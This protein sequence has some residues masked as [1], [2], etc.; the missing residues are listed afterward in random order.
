VPAVGGAPADVTK[1]TP[2]Q[3]AHFWPCFLPDGRQFL[4]YARGAAAGLYLGSLDSPDSKRIANSDTGAQFVAP[5]WLLF[6]HRGTLVAQRLDLARGEL[7][8][9]PVS[10]ADQV[11]VVAGVV[12][13]GAFS[14]SP[15]GS[16]TYRAGRTLESQLT[17]FTRSGKVAGTIGKPDADELLRPMLSPDGRRVVAQR[18]VRGNTDLWLFDAGRE[19][20]LT[21]DP[22][23]ELG[24]VWS[25]DGSRIAFSRDLKG[26]LRLYQKSIT[27][28]GAEEL[29]LAPSGNPL[30]PQAWSP[31]GRLLLYAERYPLT[32]SDLW[33]LPLDGK[34][35]FVFVNSKFEDRM[36]QFSPDGRWVAYMSDE[37]GRPEIYLRSF[38]ASGGQFSVSTTGGIMPRWR[39][40]GKELYYIAPDGTLM[41]V[42][43][44]TTGRAPEM[45]A[46]VALF[47]P[48]ILYGGRLIPGIDWQYD[49]APD[50]RFLI[51]VIV[52][53]PGTAPITV[54]QHWRAG[55]EN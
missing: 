25:P 55:I 32:A 17:W 35:P 45:S 6:V 16:I 12:A 31:D 42:S 52:G 21:S 8:G 49:V 51:N 30:Y 11:S 19:T 7:T 48:P 15:A 41:A 9:E 38:A 46:P 33:V 40:D 13:A 2:D 29:L 53:D 1:L 37:S 24:H 3:T 26:Q 47:Q 20:R 39:K 18:T 14:V 54:I 28:G 5:D 4:F 10:V 34:P 50:N 36:P 27:G 43:M 44:T 23:A 22:G